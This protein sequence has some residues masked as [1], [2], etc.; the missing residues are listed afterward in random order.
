MNSAQK[1]GVV[2]IV[3]GVMIIV[4][5]L[6]GSIVRMIMNAITS[7]YALA[8]VG[9]FICVI[10]A[11]FALSTTVTNESKGEYDGKKLP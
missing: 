11:A 6:F 2:L 10:G 1:Y 3:I 7:Q 9:L 5:S 4:Y 8:G